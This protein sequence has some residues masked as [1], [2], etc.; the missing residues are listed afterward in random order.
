MSQRSCAIL[1]ACSKACVYSSYPCVIAEEL[2]SKNGRIAELESQVKSL[3]EDLAR[4]VA[5]NKRLK[6]FREVLEVKADSK[7]EVRQKRFAV[8]AEP[9]R[10]DLA[11]AQLVKTSKPQR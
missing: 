6:R 2:K 3:Q 11:G 4:V 7:V 5:E 9:G 1:T 10:D 8:S